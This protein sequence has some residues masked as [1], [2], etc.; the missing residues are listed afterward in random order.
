MEIKRLTDPDSEQLLIFFKECERLGIE[1]NVSLKSIKYDWTINERKGMF[2]TVHHEGRMIGMSGCHWMP[3]I[4]ENAFRILFRGCELPFSDIKKGLSR[5]QFNSFNFR[6][7]IPFQID[8]L[9]SQNQNFEPFITTNLSNPNNRAMELI[10]KQGF[11]TK[12]CE[13]EFF[14]TEQIVWKFNTDHYFNIRSKIKTYT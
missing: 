9:K 13:G 3:E 12:Y 5:S 2:W 8:W 6:E 7:V 1:N 4:K 10:A 11:L 14:Y